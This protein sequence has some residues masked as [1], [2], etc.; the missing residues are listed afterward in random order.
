MDTNTAARTEGAE[1][2]D[3]KVVDLNTVLKEGS[4][5][6]PTSSNIKMVVYHGAS[7]SLIIQFTNSSAYLYKGVP[8]LIFDEIVAAG[9]AGSYF[10]K[11]IRDKYETEKLASLEVTENPEQTQA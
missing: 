10:A 4:K 11:N 2:T 3:E 1:T 8:S 7:L 9:S 5:F 6:I